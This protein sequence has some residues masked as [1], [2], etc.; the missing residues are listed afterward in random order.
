MGLIRQQCLSDM[1]FQKNSFKK[2]YVKGT[3]LAYVNNML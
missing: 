3:N 2:L 1:L